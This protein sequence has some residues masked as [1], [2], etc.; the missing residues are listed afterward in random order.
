[1]FLFFSSV[2]HAALTERWVGIVLSPEIIW[3]VNYVI[4]KLLLESRRSNTGGKGKPW[5]LQAKPNH[6]IS[7][8][9]SIFFKTNIMSL[10]EDSSYLNA[11]PAW[12]RGLLQRKHHHQGETAKKD[13]YRCPWLM[14]RG[15]TNGFSLNVSLCA[16]SF[17]LKGN[18]SAWQSYSV[19]C[20][21]EL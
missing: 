1:M 10:G 21:L 9:I 19:F 2:V 5:K 16:Y 18:S 8:L 20:F 11:I 14:A 4:K 3:V 13:N 15:E 12:I 6:I 7:L 17:L